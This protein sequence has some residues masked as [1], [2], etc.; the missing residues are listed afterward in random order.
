MKDR[1]FRILIAGN[2]NYGSKLKVYKNL[3]DFYER[4]NGQIQ[5]AIFNSKYGA[6]KMAFQYSMK[7]EL[8][9]KYFEVSDIKAVKNIAYHINLNQAVKW[10]DILLIFSNHH[11][12]EIDKLINLMQSKKKK[13][14]I[15][16]E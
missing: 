3:E 14:M 11:S 7:K 5:I 15:I 13:Y 12:N 6:E 9:I 4:L 2:H 1:K 16:K 10:C 8:P